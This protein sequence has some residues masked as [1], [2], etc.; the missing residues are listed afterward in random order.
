MPRAAVVDGLIALLGK[1]NIDTLQL[2]MDLVLEALF[3]RP[4]GRVWCAEALVWA[5][6]RS[7]ANAAVYSLDEWFPDEGITVLRSAGGGSF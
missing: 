1:P 5:A 4:S 3:C 2:E 7:Q 6:G